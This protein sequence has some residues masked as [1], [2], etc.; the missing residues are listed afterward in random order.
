MK[1]VG[2]SAVGLWVVLVRRLREHLVGRVFVFLVKNVAKS[3]RNLAMTPPCTTTPSM[4]PKKLIRLSVVQ[5]LLFLI[6][7]V[8][9]RLH[10]HLNIPSP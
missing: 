6:R 5:P 8:I 2:E 7:S 1:S 4:T 3:V 9:N 10:I